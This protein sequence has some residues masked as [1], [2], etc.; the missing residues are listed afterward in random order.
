MPLS[1]RWFTWLALWVAFPCLAQQ[2]LHSIDPVQS[3]FGFEI[4]TRFG[5]KIEGFFPRFRGELAELPNGRQQVRFRLDATQVEIPAK[6]RYTSWM[7][8]EDFFDVARYPVVEFESFPYPAEVVKK[9][10]DITGNLTIRG[11][12]HVETLHVVPADCARP[13]YDCDVISRG[14]VLRGRYGMN[15]WQMALGDRVTFILRGRL[16]EARRP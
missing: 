11:I 1:L 5:M 16:Q 13:G 3:R 10:G 12:T 6:D 7:R 15:A 14:T 2:T 9:G 8:G 4:R